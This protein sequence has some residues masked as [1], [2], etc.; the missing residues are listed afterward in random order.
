L[1]DGPLAV[2]LAK[3]AIDARPK[4]GSYRNTLGVAL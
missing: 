4:T 3:K 1:R 2:H